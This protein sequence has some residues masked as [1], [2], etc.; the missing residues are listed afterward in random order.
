M[1]YTKII[2]SFFAILYSSSSI[3]A[4]PV[5]ESKIPV[6]EISE[7]F[8]VTDVETRRY[9]GRVTSISSVTLVPR[10]SGEILEIGFHDGDQIKTGQML[11]RIDPVQ[12]EAAVKSAEASVVQYRAEHKYAKADLSRNRTLFKRTAISQDVLENA[13]RA[14]KVAYGQLLA[15]EAELVRA[16]DDL[17]NTEITAPISGRIGVTAFTVGNYI[18]PSSGTLATLIQNDPVRVRFA[19]STRDM[20]FRFGS[21]EKLKK[22]GK[23]RVRLS[24]NTEYEGEGKISIVDNAANG[25]T[26]TIQVYAEFANSEGRL[27]VGSTVT[28]TL[29]RELEGKII[30]AVPPSAI[31]HDA[32]GAFVYT[33]TDDAH[34]QK[35]RIELGNLIGHAQTVISGISLHERVVSDGMHKIADGIL[36]EGVDADASKQ[37]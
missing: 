22:Y 28:V 34:V 26:D 30:P 35:R 29:S 19:L 17:R 25:R 5:S 27:V 20:L 6:V 3:A 36:V 32:E 37:S 7:V 31:Q 10:V 4:E 2:L 13:E 18:T 24:D 12:Y 33:V 21:E 11:Y 8:A 9:T 16:N 23:V 1:T 15:A 14:E